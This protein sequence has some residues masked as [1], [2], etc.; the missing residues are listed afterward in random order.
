MLAQLSQFLGAGAGCCLGLKSQDTCSRC[1]H[2]PE[3][4]PTWGC[5]FCCDWQFLSV[6]N[7]I[8]CNHLLIYLDVL[9]LET[10]HLS[11]TLLPTFSFN[12][13]DTGHTVN[14][15]CTLRELAYCPHCFLPTQAAT[16]S[17]S[18]HASSA[19]PQACPS[20]QPVEGSSPHCLHSP[21]LRSRSGS[22]LLGPVLSASSACTAPRSPDTGLEGITLLSVLSVPQH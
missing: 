22:H 21:Q 9:Y 5:Q 19:G 6:L 2:G 20:L 12:V 7:R 10:K 16:Q 17:E 18:C 15:A 11:P 4:F 3:S 1:C 8:F 14:Q 13:A